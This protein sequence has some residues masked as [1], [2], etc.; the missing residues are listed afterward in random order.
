MTTDIN[1][2][3]H[4]LD[5]ERHD[6]LVD[7]LRDGAGLTGTKLVCGAGVC[8]ACTVH[9]DG[10][11]VV[12]CLVPTA[13]A[14]GGTVTTVEGVGSGSD[15]ALHP[16]QRALAHEDGLQ[17]G[18]CTP[19][20]VMDAVVFV[21][22]WRSRGVSPDDA[23]PDLASGDRTASGTGSTASGTGRTPSDVVAVV[24][25]SATVAAALSGHLCRCGAYPGIVRAVQRACAGDFDRPGELGPQRVEA[26][27]K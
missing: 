4:T 22:T 14:E 12:S 18:F 23:A 13:H 17:C 19:G 10:E 24:P 7:A 27:A 15:D 3:P 1:G 20:F 8:G 5:P 9:L 21:D 6:T 25:D 16:V 2:Q 11:P 26:H